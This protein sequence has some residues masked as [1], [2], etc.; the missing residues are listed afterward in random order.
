MIETLGEGE[1]YGGVSMVLDAGRDY[2]KKE[3]GV[4]RE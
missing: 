4:R 2:K 3:D 1:D